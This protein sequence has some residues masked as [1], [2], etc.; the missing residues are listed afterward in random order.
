MK[1]CL[2]QSHKHI[3]SINYLEIVNF[4]SFENLEEAYLASYLSLIFSLV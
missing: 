3:I 2:H 1:I 4:F